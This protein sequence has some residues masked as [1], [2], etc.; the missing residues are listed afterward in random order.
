LLKPKRLQDLLDESIITKQFD[1]VKK[2]AEVKFNS[3]KSIKSTE[4]TTIINTFSK[5]GDIEKALEVFHAIGT[6]DNMRARPNN[7]Q[8]SSI[9][10]ACAANGLWEKSVEIFNDMVIADHFR[11]N[12]F[13]YTSILKSM[14]KNDKYGYA[15]KIYS[16]M[17]KS[18]VYMDTSLYNAG[19]H[20]LLKN[21]K[22]SDSLELFNEMQTKSITRD[23][24]TYS[25]MMAVCDHSS[26]GDLA[27]DLL[28]KMHAIPNF[29]PNIKIYTS[30]VS[31]LV[32][33]GKIQE[34]MNLYEDIR[35]YPGILL[36]S[37]FY[38]AMLFACA[39]PSN[40][41]GHMK[42]V[43][44]LNEMN[45]RM[46]RLSVFGL[47]SAITC[48]DNYG[49]YDESKKMFQFGIKEGIIGYDMI[50]LD[51][52]RVDL[53]NKKKCYARALLGDFV[54]K[55][56]SGEKGINNYFFIVGM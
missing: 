45:R 34:V 16:N 32:K 26:N 27:W 43:D 12:P 3:N 39:H 38:G 51:A 24:A 1:E 9:I 42:C 44:I 22:F 7:F 48:Y 40:T 37:P 53:R 17:R 55:L 21:K 35:Q 25:I 49:L 46:V 10:N 31:A 30:A 47:E 20:V 13:V 36:D 28:R 18:N 19:M 11:P 54:E 4:L 29:N 15:L 56:L 41:S 6:K 50:Y 14:M 33:G 5:A 2:L 8:Y 52:C 23:P